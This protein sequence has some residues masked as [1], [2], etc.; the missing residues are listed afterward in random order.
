MG[1]KGFKV[2]GFD[3][4]NRG[5]V[6]RKFGKDSFF[7]ITPPRVLCLKGLNYQGFIVG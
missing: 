3:G 6:I 4:G 1:T 5:V 2:S 7:L